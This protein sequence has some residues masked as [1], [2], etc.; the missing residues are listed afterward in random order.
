MRRTLSD[1]GVA[2]LKPR[3]QRY[4]FPDPQLTGHYVRVQ[5]S[6]AKSF[7]VV[8]LDPYAK[9]IWSTIGAADVMSIDDARERGRETIR[10]IK[11]GLP[12]SEPVPVKPDSFKVIAENW[13]R[14]H[15]AKE[16]L[17]TAPE[18]A[19][20]LNVYVYPRWADRPFTGIRRKDVAD[21]IDAI[22]DTN[23]SRMADI[24]FGILRSI[25]NWYGLRDEAYL[26]PFARGMR[27]S[28]GNKRSRILDD[29]ELRK[30]WKAAEA[31][32]GFGAL[33]RTLLL[34]TQRLGAV[35]G[36]RWDDIDENGVWTIPSED[37]EK[38]NAGTLRLPRLAL[39][40][41]NAQPKLGDNPYVFAA[42]RG[43]GPM[44]SFSKTKR[45][46]DKRCGVT[47]WAMHDCRRVARSLMS[48][49]GV[50][51]DIAERTLG[52]VVGGDIAQV[53]DRHEYAT[54]KGLALEQL[55]T[56]IDGIVNPRE[57]VVPMTERKKRR[58]Q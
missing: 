44:N 2:A 24:V 22:E 13:L 52:H 51:P 36:M 19:R 14:R 25:G 39:G 26:T 32:N 47:D 15:V 1:K 58:R 5:P 21:L 54:E 28:K 35:L 27:Q 31:S 41:I 11:A 18:I 17:R 29:A 30:V 12:P 42:S 10:R 37:R 20:C 46:F 3:R 8:A 48:R 38:P 9:Q 43:D 40:I 34:T 56:L 50:R 16:K 53:Y 4:A 45:A 33:I 7:V 23:G 57:N 49:A 55:A 6:G